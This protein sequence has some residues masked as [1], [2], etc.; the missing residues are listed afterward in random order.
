M[1]VALV[2][3]GHWDMQWA[4]STT[5]TLNGLKRVFPLRQ[6]QGLRSRK[7][8]AV[9]GQVG[10]SSHEPCA[11]QIGALNYGPLDCRVL[12]WSTIR[13]TRG[14]TTITALLFEDKWKCLEAHTL[15]KLCYVGSEMN[16]FLPRYTARMDLS[17]SSFRVRFEEPR[18][19][20]A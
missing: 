7:E 11:C 9:S 12:T 16:T 5:T 15:A 18:Q 1:L 13:V 10:L 3:K 14:D 20:R 19:S 8:K 2:A 6:G 17:C 4:S